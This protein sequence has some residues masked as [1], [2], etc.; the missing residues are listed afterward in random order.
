MRA[1]GIARET[2]RDKK[3]KKSSKL[4]R[5]SLLS[6]PPSA[7]RPRGPRDSTS[8]LAQLR[9]ARRS[10]GLACSV[11]G[12]SH[13]G[14]GSEEGE[15]EEEVEGEEEEVEG[16]DEAKRLAASTAEVDDDAS[17]GGHSRRELHQFRRGA[18]ATG[19]VRSHSNWR[20]CGIEHRRARE[21][22]LAPRKRA[23]AC[24]GPLAFFFEFEAFRKSLLILVAF[25]TCLPFSLSSSAHPPVPLSFSRR[26]LSRRAHSPLRSSCA[27]QRGAHKRPGGVVGQGREIKKALCNDASRRRR[28]LPGQELAVLQGWSASVCVGGAVSVAF[29]RAACRCRSCGGWQKGASE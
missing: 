13:S 8:S 20:R 9:Q 17:R 16:E 15:E 22:P 3:K 26:A 10:R 5:S 29:R 18:R 4:T 19:T 28:R 24:I 25:S 21:R 7:E 11:A 23:R 6:G 2:R 27:S 1:G 12:S 14:S